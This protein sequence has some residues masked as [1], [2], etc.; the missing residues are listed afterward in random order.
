MQNIKTFGH[1]IYKNSYL[2]VIAG[3]LITISFII[4]N[5]WSDNS[6]IGSVKKKIETYIHQQEKDFQKLSSD[7]ALLNKLSA[8]NY[9]E[10]FLNAFTQKKY[11][12]YQYQ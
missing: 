6:S 11:F 7:T 8:K 1:F 2:L 5:Y 10:D 9:D 3:W 12:F 4:D